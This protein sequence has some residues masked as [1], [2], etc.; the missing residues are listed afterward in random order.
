MV[1]NGASEDMRGTTVA[2]REQTRAALHP[3]LGV[4]SHALG[5]SCRVYGT[6]IGPQDL[7]IR[8]ACRRRGKNAYQVAVFDM[9]RKTFH[10]AFICTCICRYIVCACVKQNYSARIDTIALSLPPSMV[11]LRSFIFL[12]QAFKLI[13]TPRQIL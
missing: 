1:P 12:L 10:Q 11:H 3:M 8:G 13:C 9:A 6:R 5:R 2:V 7:S 4:R